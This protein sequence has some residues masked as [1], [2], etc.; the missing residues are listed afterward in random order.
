MMLNMK[1]FENYSFWCIYQMRTGRPELNLRPVASLGGWLG[2]MGRTSVVMG[3]AYLFDWQG[4]VP[5]RVKRVGDV[6]AVRAPQRTL[7]LAYKQVCNMANYVYDLIFH[8]F[9]YITT[10]IEA[11]MLRILTYHKQV[12]HQSPIKFSKVKLHCKMNVDRMR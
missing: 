2:Q 7:Q 10:N 4:E 8:C 5:E 3:V 1:S 9:T 6:A 12:A 11:N